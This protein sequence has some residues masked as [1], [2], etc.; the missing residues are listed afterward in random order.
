VNKLEVAMVLDN[1]GSM[2]GTKL[3]TL[4]TAAS[5]FVD[6]LSS[7]AARSADPDAVKIGLVP[8]SMTVKVG[9][10]YQGAPGWTPRRRAD[11]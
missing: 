1:T 5:N 9:S 7:A 6:T 3:S 8:F 2:A 11:Q 4:K 10:G